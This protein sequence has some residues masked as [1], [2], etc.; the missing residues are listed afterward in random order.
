[1]NGCCSL[2]NHTLE[3]R[4]GHLNSVSVFQ[5]LNTFDVSA[6]TVATGLIFLH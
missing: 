2:E 6:S 3:K 4:N 5:Q 1:M